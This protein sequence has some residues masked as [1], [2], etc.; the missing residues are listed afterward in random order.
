MNSANHYQNVF[1][2]YKIMCNHQFMFNF[3]LNKTKSITFSGIIIPILLSLTIVCALS[4]VIIN[5]EMIARD[6][7]DKEAHQQACND[8]CDP[9]VVRECGTKYVV[10]GSTVPGRP[11][12]KSLE[13][14]EN[15]QIIL[16]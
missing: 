8:M 11:T 13:N 16:Q 4:W 12:L 14:S 6:L 7:R 15:T 5:L 1:L 10:C 3:L 9:Y 2:L